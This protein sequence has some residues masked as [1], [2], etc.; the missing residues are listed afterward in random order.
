MEDIEIFRAVKYLRQF[1]HK[2][3]VYIFHPSCDADQMKEQVSEWFYSMEGITFVCNSGE[4][5]YHDVGIATSWETVYVFRHQENHFRNIFYFVQDF[6]PYFSALS[7]GYYLAENTYK[8]GLTHICSGPWI[9]K[10]LRERYHAES[11]Y[12]QFPLDTKIYNTNHL[13]TKKNKNIVFFAKPE[14]PRRCFE[15]GIEALKC[16]KEKNA[17]VEIIMFGSNILTSSM[18]PFSATI[19]N[20]VPTLEGLAEVYANADLGIVFSPTNPSL[21][22]YEMM[23]CGCPVVD[24]DVDLALAKYGNDENNIFLLDPLPDRFASELQEILY[25]DELLTKHRNSALEWVKNEFPS[26]YEMAK[27]VEDCIVTKLK[28]GA[29]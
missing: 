28:T 10:V 20:Y 8:L 29:I 11:R 6:E 24:L 25:N 13:R 3:T 18:V 17:D 26:E 21:V 27:I 22:P 12:F 2:V 14:M 9:D 5:G 15:L 1:G 16:F 23:S 7:S 4:L 19:M